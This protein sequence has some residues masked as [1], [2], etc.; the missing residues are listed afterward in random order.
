M[1]MWKLWWEMARQLRG[2]C[3]R[4]RTFM[5]LAA[6]LAGMTVRKDLLGVTSIVRVLGLKPEYYDRILDFFH[7]PAL[8]IMKLTRTWVRT[9]FGFHPGLLRINGRAALVGDG[10][11][12]GKSGRKMPAVKSL[13]QESESNTKPK[14]IMGHSCQAI[15]VLAKAGQSVFAIP[16]ACRIHEGAVFSNRDRRTLLDKMIILINSLE[17]KEKC[18]F[19]ADAYYA[20]GKIVKGMLKDGHHLV[21]MVKKNSVAY[22]PP[23]PQQKPRKRGRPRKYGE[24][25][26]LRDYLKDVDSMQAAPSPVYGEKNVIIRF[27]SLDLLWRPAGIM[28]RFVFVHHP[29]RG[30]MILMTTDLTLEPIEVIRIYGFRFKIEVS[31]KSALRTIGTYAYHFWMKAMTPIKRWSGDQHLHKK[32]ESYRKGIRRKIDAYHRHIQ[33]GVIAQG[34][35]QCLASTHTNM[36]WKNFG[37]WIRTIRPG[38]PPSELVSAIAMRDCLPEFIADS[39]CD[40]IFAKFLRDRIDISRVEGFQM[41]A[42]NE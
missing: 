9:V 30:T 16:L 37:S 1:K 6:V 34:L 40:A 26:Y 5:W 29:N 10:I 14:Y 15:A 20:S 2:A 35:L 8:D 17:L 25:V 11:K 7:S 19:T 28:V 4:E 13:R 12:V 27:R 36:V 33:I 18:Y 23:I 39:S 41:I 22:R 42:V 3:S 38:I 32:S 21:T 24:K 31:F